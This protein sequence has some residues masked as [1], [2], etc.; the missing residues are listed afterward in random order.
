MLGWKTR[1]ILSWESIQ[2]YKRSVIE[3]IQY[4]NGQNNKF[5][6][7]LKE[8][9]IN[10]INRALR[11]NNWWS[12]LINSKSI[13]ERRD[14][15]QKMKDK[16]NRNNKEDKNQCYNSEYSYAKSKYESTKNVSNSTVGI[17]F[18]FSRTNSAVPKSYEEKQEEK[19][20]KKVEE[21][22]QKKKTNF[23]RKRTNLKYDPMKAADDEK[24]K[25][26]YM[27][28]CDKV[29]FTIGDDSILTDNQPIPTATTIKLGDLIEKEKR[30]KDLK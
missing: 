3:L 9:Y 14:R 2:N 15:I 6:Q 10:A 13:Q 16:R 19:R 30:R 21:N 4:Y 5:V 24:A 20:R 25:R 28:K 12:D 27:S 18:D 26:E 7:K 23:L 22:R 11:N 8:D 17:A 29:S 1:K